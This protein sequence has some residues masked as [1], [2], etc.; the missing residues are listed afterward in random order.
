MDKEKLA[1]LLNEVFISG[2]AYGMARQAKV[3][4]QEYHIVDEKTNKILFSDFSASDLAMSFYS[5]A[6]IPSALKN[7]K[8]VN[9]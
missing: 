7:N 4:A 8:E 5:E 3:D 1:E 6:I 9:L 2:V